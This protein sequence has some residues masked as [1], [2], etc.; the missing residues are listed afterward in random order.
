MTD[1][2]DFALVAWRSLLG[3]THVL[4]DGAALH[5]AQTATFATEQQLPAILRPDSRPAVQEC[6]RIASQFRISINPISGG[7]NWGFG[8]RVGPGDEAVVL[9]L[10]RM[11]RIVAFDERLAYLTVE[12]GVTFRQAQAF[13]RERTSRLALAVIGG[14]PE[15]SII[16]NFLV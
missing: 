7:R 14:P 2:L 8:S 12:P 13:L 16:G 3:D 15:G 9:D 6:L 1:S 10:G 4:T 5:S 11:N